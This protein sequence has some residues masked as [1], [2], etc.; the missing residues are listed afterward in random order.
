[1]TLCLTMIVKNESK[2]LR[3]CFDS[4]RKYLDYWVICDTGS[5]DGTQDLI[6]KYF[7]EAKIPGEL[8][9]HEW[10]NFGH[11][12]SLAISLSRKKA[13]LLLLLDADMEVH[14][15]DPMF[16]ETLSKTDAT[17]FLIKYTGKLNYRQNLLVS[18]RPEWRYVGVTHEYIT[19]DDA[20]SIQTD[21]ISI[22]HHADGGCRSDKFERDIVLLT[23]GLEAEPKN[24][25]YCF[26][27]ARSYE[28]L[29][30][31]AEALKYYKLR[32]KGGGWLEE[33]YYSLYKVGVCMEKMNASFEDISTAY[34]N[35]YKFRPCRLEAI[36]S[37]VTLC[38]NT[39][40]FEEGFRFGIRAYGT[41]YPSDILFVEDDVYTW[42][43]EDELA[44]CACFTNRKKFASFLYSGINFPESQKERVAKNLT[45]FV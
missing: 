16:K 8:H 12:R 39:R 20:R 41:T 44:I 25:R 37:L 45:F 15:A 6:R 36:C 23:K 7:E 42:R 24:V 22:T 43:F 27:L 21:L 33:V 1:M 30:R 5:T 18:G 26:Y 19:S 9:Q 2:N 35:A 3:R 38:R 10:K 34:I 14:V 28:D 13:D 17:G 4:V 40:R 31:Y 29:G 11:N 32:I